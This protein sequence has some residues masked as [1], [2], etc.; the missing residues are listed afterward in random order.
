MALISLN[1]IS[2]YDLYLP[3]SILLLSQQTQPLVYLFPTN[4][5]VGQ[6]TPK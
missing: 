1:K 6:S 4:H 5:I 2:L 3:Y